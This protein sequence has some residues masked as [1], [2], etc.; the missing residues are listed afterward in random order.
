MLQINSG[1]L[2]ARRIGR[3]NHLRGVLYSNLEL[4]YGYDVVTAAGSLRETARSSTRS[5]R[6]SRRPKSDRA[7]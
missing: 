3:T 4:F 6:I 5:T 7:F 1:K 2:F